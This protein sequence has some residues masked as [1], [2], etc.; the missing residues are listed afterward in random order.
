M[1]K[2]VASTLL[3]LSVSGLACA[4]AVVGDATAGKSKAAVCSACHGMDGNS[5][6]ASFPKL[7][8]Q[9]SRYLLKQMHDIKN[10]GN[11]GGR[12]VIE[13]TGL[14]NNLSDQDMADIAAYFASQQV[15]MGAAKQDLVKLGEAIYRGGNKETGVAACTACHS[16]MGKG[17]APAGFPALGGQHAAY[18]AKQLKLFRTAAEEPAKGRTNDQAEIMRNVAHRMSDLEIEAVSSY[19]S[20]LH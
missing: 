7:A 10:A 18:I 9:N 20:G 19:I 17:N 12:T 5:A 11:E 14:L 15:T 2:F 3:A 6:V 8:G 1:K 16:P 4:E 13:M